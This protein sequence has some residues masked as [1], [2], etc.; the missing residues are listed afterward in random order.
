VNRPSKRSSTGLTAAC[1]AA[2]VAAT[3]IL[4]AGAGAGQRPISCGYVQETV[5]VS[6]HQVSCRPARKIANAYLSGSKK[7]EGFSCRKYKVNAAAGWWAKCT[8]GSTYVQITPE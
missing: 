7:P 3:L 6:A 8:R 1:C 4:P 2:A 5:A